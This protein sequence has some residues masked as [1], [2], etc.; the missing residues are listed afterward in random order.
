MTTPNH[1]TAATAVPLRTLTSVLPSSLAEAMNSLREAAQRI[2]AWL[3]A[4]R[5][6]TVD[7][8]ILARMSDRE[9]LDIG[10]DRASANVAADG[11]WKR[12]YPN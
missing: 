4:R 11:G 8:D 9:L 3:E 6:V 12:D 5:R 2:E 10:L 1:S 7:R